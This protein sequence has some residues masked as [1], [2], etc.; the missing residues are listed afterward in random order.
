MI[1]KEIYPKTKRIECD[2][3]CSCDK[4]LTKRCWKKYF[5]KKAE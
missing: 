5:I 2:E 3:E 4:D 1:K